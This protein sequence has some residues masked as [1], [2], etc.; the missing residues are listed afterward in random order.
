MVTEFRKQVDVLKADDALGLVYGYAVVCC[1]DGKPYFD[2]Y[3]DHVPESVMVKHAA[4]FMLSARVSTDM[5]ARKD[6]KPVP[7][8]TVVFAFPMTADIAKSFGF[9]NV[10]KTGLLIAM[11]P[12]PEVYAKFKSGEYTGF[13]IG[14]FR[15]EDEIVKESAA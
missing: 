12:S 6:G 3:G 2:S 4:D 9:E 15:G 14:G 1:E 10:K 11:R 5:H 7:D 8:G 13:S